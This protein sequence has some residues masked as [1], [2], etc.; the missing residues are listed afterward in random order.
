MNNTLNMEHIINTDLSQRAVVDINASNWVNSPLPGVN[1]KYLE[2]DGGDHHPQGLKRASTIVRYDPGSSYTP[3]IHHTGEEFL[4][5]EGVFS[6]E[7]GNY[8]AGT[9]ARNPWGSRHT[10]YS[11]DGCTIF[12][13]LYQIQQED[14]AQKV[15]N[16][17]D[18]A[19]ISSHNNQILTTPL[20]AYKKEKVAIERWMPNTKLD[21]QAHPGGEEIFVLEGA[22]EDDFGQ[23]QKGTWLRNPGKSTL[24]RGSKTGCLIYRKT[25]HLQDEQ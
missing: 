8:P 1:R 14:K 19:Y 5:L 17:N 13:K 9:Y 4:V 20:H 22:F 2:R 16:S 24:N 3:H 23:Y 21:Q 15:V 7:H 25:G 12:V 10:P 6:D 11:K 18:A